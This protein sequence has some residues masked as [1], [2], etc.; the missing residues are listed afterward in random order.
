METADLSLI[1]AIQLWIVHLSSA[2]DEASERELLTR[3]TQNVSVVP[4]DDS[5]NPQDHALKTLHLIQAHILLAQYLFRTGS[6]LEGKYYVQGALSLVDHT[7]QESIEISETAD[8]H[9]RIG[10]FWASFTLQNLWAIA[11][12]SSSLLRGD[13]RCMKDSAGLFFNGHDSS[14]HSLANAVCLWDRTIRFGVQHY[15]GLY[16][17]SHYFWASR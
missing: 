9:E 1:H 4:R 3:A 12:P 10:A 11:T 7:S 5:I 8:R 13:S 6:V 2:A 17:A 15:D 16:T 14:L